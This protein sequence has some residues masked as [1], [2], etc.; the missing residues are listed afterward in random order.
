MLPKALVLYGDG[1]NCEEETIFALV[2]AGFSASLLHVSDLLKDNSC[3][4]TCNL[5]VIPGGFSFA[6]EIRSGK[7]L[8]LELK[9]KLLTQLDSF[10]DQGNFLLGICNGFQVLT[11]LGLL[12]DHHLFGSHSA[13]LIGNQS[14]KFSNRWVKLIVNEEAKNPFLFGLKTM[15]LPMRHGEGQLVVKEDLADSIKQFACLRYAEDV[16]GSFDRIA[17]LTNK[18][19]NVFGIMPHPE[20]F[21]RPSQHPAW[22]KQRANDQDANRVPDGLTFFRNALAALS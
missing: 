4:N 1:I 20:A 14:G 3:L 22:T 6:D 8:A 18:T 13:A 11:A 9:N 12:P 7:V 21:I 5:F 15:S 16:N 10:I 17:A 19:G 2:I